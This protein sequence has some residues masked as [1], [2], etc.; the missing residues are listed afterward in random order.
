MTDY[1]PPTNDEARAWRNSVWAREASRFDVD[2][3]LNADDTLL[4]RQV[5]ITVIPM[6]GMEPQK[7]PPDPTPGHGPPLQTKSA[8]A[9]GPFF[10]HFV[11]L[12][13]GGEK[14]FFT[15]VW[16]DNFYGN[17]TTGR[18]SALIHV[19]P[20]STIEELADAVGS[21]RP[22]VRQG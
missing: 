17:F 9:T 15:L 2:Y 16:L 20:A 14:L 1:R 18:L 22:T 4:L 11:S 13:A 8:L 10:A 19:L 7:E 6:E 21:V 3:L 12:V 5:F